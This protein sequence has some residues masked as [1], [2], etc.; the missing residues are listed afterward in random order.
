MNLLTQEELAEHGIFI[1]NKRFGGIPKALV[2]KS[3]IKFYIGRGSPLGNEYS[4]LSHSTA[5]YKVKTREEAVQCYADSFEEII[6]EERAG[7]MFNRIK[8]AFEEG[9]IILECWCAP[10]LCH[11]Q[12]IGTFLQKSNENE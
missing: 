11:G 12:V 10:H 7:N 9:P 3:F 2:G 5:K 6:K 8:R 1:T 4:H